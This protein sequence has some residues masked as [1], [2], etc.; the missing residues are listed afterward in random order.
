[1]NRLME[2]RAA[3][4]A[5][6]A[7]FHLAEAEKWLKK[8]NRKY[9]EEELRLAKCCSQNAGALFSGHTPYDAGSYWS[10]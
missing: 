3:E 8:G 5:S 9:F 4:E 2:R 7:A 6:N 1:M 10:Y